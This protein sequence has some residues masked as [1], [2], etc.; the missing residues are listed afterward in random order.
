MSNK[1]AQSFNSNKGTNLDSIKFDGGSALDWNSS[2][3]HLQNNFAANE[4]WEYIN[5]P[6]V[7]PEDLNLI[8]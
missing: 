6:D 8:I 7:I 1:Y 5:P 3:L 4:C 2:K